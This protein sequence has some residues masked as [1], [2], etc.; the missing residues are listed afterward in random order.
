MHTGDVNTISVLKEQMNINPLFDS[1]A[2][3]KIR[4]VVT[5]AAK[6]IKL[7]DWIRDFVHMP[8]SEEELEGFIK[9]VLFQLAY[10]LIVFEKF[11]LMH[12][13]LH[14]E[15]VFVE[16]LPIPLHFS[17]DIL[18]RKIVRNVK[19]F[20]QIYDFD[21]STKVE[22]A[23]DNVVLHNTLLD[24]DF[25]DRF[26]ECNEFHKNVDW[27]TILHSMYLCSQHFGSDLPI[28]ENVVD[29]DL[30]TKSTHHGKQLVHMGRPCTRPEVGYRKCTRFPLDESLITSPFDFLRINYEEA[31]KCKPAFSLPSVPSRGSL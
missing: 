21:R 12:H 10:T 9:D 28:I 4:M 20:V 14:V 31:S 1:F 7:A 25:C 30:L 15:N 29:S 13:D 17:V 3:D 11:G 16:K 19:Y 5:K 22:T 23:F 6:G 27:V 26:G 2:L 18:D 24:S 8:I